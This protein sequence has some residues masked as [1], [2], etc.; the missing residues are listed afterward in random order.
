MT[1]TPPAKP[2]IQLL[3]LNQFPI[4]EQLQLE[5]ALLRAD[6]R[7]WLILN[8]GSPP[9]IVMG[10]S[11]APEALINKYQIA[12][13]PVPI[14]RRFSGGG[15]VFIDHNTVFAT[16]ICNT[17]HIGVPCCPQKMHLWAAQFYQQAFPNL[18]MN[19]KEND[20][21]IGEYKWGGNAQYL[22]KGRWLHH[23]SMLW[24]YHSENMQ[25]LL[26]PAKKPAYRQERPHDQFLCRLRD[27]FPH[28][29]HITSNIITKL[30]DAFHVATCSVE[31]SLE[32]LKRPH[33]KATQ[34]LPESTLN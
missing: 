20:Y 8:Y 6:D 11:G 15:T 34:L 32:I 3:L 7:N 24:D 27:H 14:I 4:Y 18:K 13:C 12:K 31:E 23:T 17:S 21:V 1:T 26:M 28:P 29:G 19:L 9:A 25:Y 5:E 22:C 2:P 30:H 16:W 33:R 10:I